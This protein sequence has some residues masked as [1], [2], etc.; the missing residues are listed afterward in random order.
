MPLFLRLR[1][2][3]LY[4]QIKHH[5]ATFD[6]NHSVTDSMKSVAASIKKLPDSVVKLT[7]RARHSQYV[8]WNDQVV[9]RVL[10]LAV[11]FLHALYI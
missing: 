4:L 7:S 5:V 2:Q 6:T 8:R 3:S 11:G 10:N 9:E 1:F